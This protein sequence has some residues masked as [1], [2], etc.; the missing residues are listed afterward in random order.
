M[1]RHVAPPRLAVQDGQP[2]SDRVSVWVAE[3]IIS[4]EQAERIRAREGLAL[5]ALAPPD[6]ASKMP[7]VIEALGYLGGAIVVVATMMIGGRYWS[8]L[9]D[10]AR[11]GL[12]GGAAL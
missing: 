4:E 5:G 10:V 6:R 7:L 9:G 11:L 8:D 12:L 1:S 2:G 3:G